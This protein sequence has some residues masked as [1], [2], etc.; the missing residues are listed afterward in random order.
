MKIEDVNGKLEIT[1]FDEFDAYRI[2][3][4][5][6]KEGIRFYE[7]LWECTKAPEA[8]RTLRFLIDEERDHL[9]FFEECLFD[10]RREKEDVSEENDI[11]QAMDFG[12]FQPFKEMRE[13]CAMID[14][15]GKALSLGVIVE[16]HAVSF[17]EACRVHIAAEKVKR[18]LDVIIR[19]EKEH[20][21]KL[22]SLLAQQK[23]S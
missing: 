1:E 22:K 10:L 9:R 20:R 8:K 18:E 7:K 16:E 19:Q 17:Y 23:A 11:F 6:E 3:C 14:S 2:A 5:V 13:M 4:T 12:I 21:E 15:P